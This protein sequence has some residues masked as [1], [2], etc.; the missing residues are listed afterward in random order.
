MIRL[1]NI[2]IQAGQFSLSNLSLSVESGQY[3]AL[4]GQTGCGKTTLVEAICGLR[5]IQGG[6]ILIGSEDVTHASPAH[7]NIG[8]VPQDLAL[9]PT[10]TVKQHLEFAL[11]LKG[12]TKSWIGQRAQQLAEQLSIDHLLDRLPKGL[13]GGE[14]QR[15]ALGRALSFQPPVLLLD[16]PLSALDDETREGLV[17]LLKRLKETRSVTVIH[18]THN[19]GEAEA[20]GDRVIRLK[21]CYGSSATA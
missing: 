9:F 18:I 19:R 20:L 15:V 21:D 6:K 17:E 7:R 13:S 11:R 10:M 2:T 4:M 8:Y 14:S 16:E 1:E 3:V 12:A 5:T